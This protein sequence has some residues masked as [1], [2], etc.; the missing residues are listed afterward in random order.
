MQRKT[1]SWAKSTIEEWRSKVPHQQIQVRKELSPT[2]HSVNPCR[3]KFVSHGPCGASAAGNSH[4]LLNCPCV[5]GGC[6][7]CLCLPFS[8]CDNVFCAAWAT[9]LCFVSCFCFP[10]VLFILLSSMNATDVTCLVWGQGMTPVLRHYF[11]KSW[12]RTGQKS[13]ATFLH[14]LWRVAHCIIVCNLW[15]HKNVHCFDIGA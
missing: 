14:G 1:C 7:T 13:E 5:P 15:S 12:C 8:K 4:V 3:S 10:I 2:T 6:G 9:N 11:Q